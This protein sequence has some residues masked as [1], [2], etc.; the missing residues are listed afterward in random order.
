MNIKE[1]KEQIVS[2]RSKHVH[3]FGEM[4]K[5]ADIQHMLSFEL[6]SD[7]DFDVMDFYYDRILS[8]ILKDSR[9]RSERFGFEEGYEWGKAYLRHFVGYDAHVSKKRQPA[10]RTSAAY[11]LLLG[12]LDAECWKCDDVRR[13]RLGLPHRKSTME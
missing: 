6:E 13:D 8:K 3:S 7:L 9:E 11:D 1:I 5:M 12:M 2:Y 4:C 10:L